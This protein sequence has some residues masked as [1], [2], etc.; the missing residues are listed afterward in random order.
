MTIGT[1]AGRTRLTR[2]GLL[3]RAAA[4]LVLLAPPILVAVG[5]A[6]PPWMLV[7]LSLALFALLWAIRLHAAP[8]LLVFAVVLAAT[9]VVRDQPLNVAAPVR[10]ADSG[11]ALA[12]TWSDAGAFD[13]TLPIV[14]HIILDELTAPG[15]VD[16]G[17]PGGA[18]FAARLRDFGR[19]EGFRTFDSIYAR[20][21]LTHHGIA[22][23]V[24]AEYEGRSASF[25]LSA[26]LVPALEENAY[27]RDMAARG[28]RTAV[29]QSAVLDYCASADVDLCETF[30]SYDPAAGD[31]QGRDGRAGALHVWDTVLAAYQPSFLASAGAWITRRAFGLQHRPDGVL[32][33]ANRYDVQ[34]FPSWF[35]RFG[36]FAA[37]V[38]RGTH[39]FAHVLA[40][41]SPYLLTKDCVV[42]G[43]FDSGYYLSDRFPEGAQ[44]EQARDR[45]FGLYFEQAT[46]VVDAAERLVHTLVQNPR[47]DD[48]VFL[49]HG[50]H[51]ARISSGFVAEDFRRRDFVDNYGTFLAVKAPEL[52]PGLDCTFMSLPEVV[53]AVL[54][55][56]RTPVAARP[57]RSVLVES[58]ARGGA[59]AEYEMPVFGCAAG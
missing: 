23:L 8:I 50:D 5:V 17:L 22:N 52:A 12:R 57:P 48:A 43:E 45:Y 30:P 29:F 15:A 20:H 36:A 32:G 33:V 31:Q 40:P 38:P 49:V 59:W 24:N 7:S 10:P 26:R 16:A 3:Y 41:H 42:G 35:D 55:T 53:A 46:C 25:E 58:R 4:A 54:Q 47:F 1:D 14:V 39:L 34:G 44:R 37:R 6:A 51:G 27:F 28:Y 56:G 2:S 9:T 11:A 13:T 21:A 18:A 19:D